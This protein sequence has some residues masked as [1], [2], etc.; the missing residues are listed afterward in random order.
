MRRVAWAAGDVTVVEVAPDALL[1]YRNGV[2]TGSAWK[3][4]KDESWRAWRPDRDGG[5]VVRGLKG[6]LQAVMYLAAVI[7]DAA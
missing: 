1:R 6:R 5:L 4:T 7:P 3:S 2:E